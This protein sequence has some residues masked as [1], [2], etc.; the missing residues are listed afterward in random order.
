M[1]SLLFVQALFAVSLCTATDCSSR[2][3]ST[4]SESEICALTDDCL[5]SLSEASAASLAKNSSTVKCIKLKNV[6]DDLLHH[7]V[8]LLLGSEKFLSIQDRNTDSGWCTALLTAL[9]ESKV[10]KSYSD[11]LN[12]KIGISAENSAKYAPFEGP[13]CN[14]GNILPGGSLNP[15]IEDRLSNRC[16]HHIVKNF[17]EENFK[18]VITGLYKDELIMPIRPDTSQLIADKYCIEETFKNL[19]LV[20]KIGTSLQKSCES[21]IKFLVYQDLKIS[22]SHQTALSITRHKNFEAMFPSMTG[23]HSC[24]IKDMLPGLSVAQLE[25]TD[26]ETLSYLNIGRESLKESDFSSPEAYKVYLRKVEETCENDPSINYVVSK[27]NGGGEDTD[28]ASTV[29]STNLEKSKDLTKKI[30]KLQEEKLKKLEEIENRRRSLDRKY[31]D[32]KHDG[33]SSGTEGSSNSFYFLSVSIL[34]SWFMQ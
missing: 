31:N 8:P 28:Q 21:L 9:D 20:L 34:F 33:R 23:I 25:K 27:Q 22:M 15:N 11:L 14:E 6:K 16:L 5:A 4:A 17:S 3:F 19:S 12:E 13:L 32:S 7:F 2:D 29:D 24:I 18:K 1:R 10:T 30:E 26:A